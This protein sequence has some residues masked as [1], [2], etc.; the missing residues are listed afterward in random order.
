M[1][2]TLCALGFLVA[3]GTAGSA[4]AAQDSAGEI[5]A[6]RAEIEALTARLDRL[7]HTTANAAP[8]AKNAAPATPPAATEVLAAAEP[9]LRFA[10]DFRYRHEAINEEG[11]AERERQRIRARFGVTA[12]VNEK[13]RVGLTLATGDDDPISGNQTLD[14]G[15]SR[16]S[17]G[18]D[19]AFFAWQATD[20]LSITGGKMANPFFRPGNHHLIYDSDLNPEGLAL[21]YSRGN[22]FVNY[23]GL[24]VDERSG[25]DDS[26]LLGGQVGHRSTLDNGMRLTVGASYYDYLNTQG[27]TPFFDGAPAGNRVTALGNYLND[28]NETELFGEISLKAG[29]RPLSVF[30]DYV[31]N[32]EADSANSGFAIGATYGEVSGPGT[33]RFG[34][35]Y[36]RLEADAVIGT[37]TDSDFGG[38]GTDSKG[39]VLE[40]SYGLR[41]RWAFG[42]RYFLNQRGID[43][44]NQRDYNRL[45]ADLTFAY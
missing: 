1:R 35:A 18:V 24:W 7:E 26:I 21:R 22:W 37:F 43:A 17:F 39:H 34:Y 40:F 28:F 31:N 14:G 29:E 11:L 3:F 12:D 9:K 4:G 5:A 32:G 27:R 33:W 41:E 10:G 16:K 25:A 44:G 38:G 36:E 6:I 8:A 23:A 42:V 15:F 45:Q 30:A 19:R 20:Q 2:N 13:V